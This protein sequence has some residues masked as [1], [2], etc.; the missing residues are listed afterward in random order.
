ME[1]AKQRV[2]RPS[3]PRAASDNAPASSEAAALLTDD[4]DSDE[5]AERYELLPM[6][7]QLLDKLLNMDIKREFKAGWL[8]GRIIRIDVGM[9]AGQKFYYALY[10]DGDT[11][12]LTL[13]QANTGW[14]AT[15]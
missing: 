4:S 6:A 12:H 1:T 9:R 10:S 5:D 3:T 2:G 15:L 11:K 14:V 8:T 7:E 13:G